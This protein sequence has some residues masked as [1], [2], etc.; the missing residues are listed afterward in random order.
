MGPAI[1]YDPATIK[2]VNKILRTNVSVAQAI[3]GVYVSQMGEI[4]TDLM[5]VYKF[6]SQEIN[7][8]VEKGGAIQTKS[9]E[10][11]AM[12]SAK[13]ETLKLVQT[14]V[15]H[16]D[17]P[18]M[19]ST[20]FLPALLEPV[21]R[22]YQHSIPDARES[23]VLSMLATCINTLKDSMAGSVPSILEAVFEVT[24]QMITRNFEDFPEH[25]VNFF[26]LLKAVNNHCFVAL[27]SI[28]PEHQKLVVDSIVW[29]F[30]HTER[31]ISDT[32]LETLH[33]LLINVRS[34]NEIAQSFYSSFYLVLLQDIL[35]VLTD[36]L[37]KNG[38]KMH[39]TILKHMFSLVEAG[40]ITAPLDPSVSGGRTNSAFMREHVVKMIST[41]FPNMSQ[42]Q[43]QTFVQGSFDMNKTLPQFKEH[44]RDFLVNVKEFAGE[45]NADLY[46]EETLQ[47]KLDADKQVRAAQMAVPGMVSPNEAGDMDDL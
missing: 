26:V 25:R 45:D 16:C 46:R 40:E 27:F 2:E 4:F 39:A 3:G 21:L 44:L 12:R 42:Q 31:N 34:H 43:V 28:P 18:A 38:F 30:K 7:S 8:R 10:V 23:G 24:L 6:Y 36:R 1:L 32:G 29:A 22:D 13:R 9:T 37:H 11:R 41:S 33:S 14:F 35:A 47:K 15:E 17:D 20:H 5:N 19:V